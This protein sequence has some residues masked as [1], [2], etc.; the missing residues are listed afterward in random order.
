MTAEKEEGGEE[1]GK[2]GRGEWLSVTSRT[3]LTCKLLSTSQSW[4]ALGKKRVFLKP[5]LGVLF[6]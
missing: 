1:G 3:K 2:C 5:R 6:Q 4:G